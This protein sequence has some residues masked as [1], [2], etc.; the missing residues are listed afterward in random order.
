MFNEGG[1]MD[2][3][4]NC[5]KVLIDL[6]TEEGYELVSVWDGEEWHK[7]DFIANA[8]A[9]DEAMLKFKKD[10]DVIKFYMI[11]GNATYESIADYTVSEIADKVT[12]KFWNHFDSQ[13]KLY[14]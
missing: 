6:M 4:E 10:D 7:E 13:A 9:S 5:T 12:D 3:W 8:T 1:I 11:W 2:K 14:S